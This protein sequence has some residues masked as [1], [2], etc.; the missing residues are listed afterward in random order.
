MIRETGRGQEA[1]PPQPNRWCFIG[2]A[3]GCWAGASQVFG[4]GADQDSDGKSSAGLCLRRC[5][6]LGRGRRCVAGQEPPFLDAGAAPLR[7]LDNCWC[8]VGQ[9][10]SA[11]GQGP[12]KTLGQGPPKIVTIIVPLVYACGAVLHRAGATVEALGRGVPR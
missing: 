12:P 8:C 10:R 3:A 5:V 6:A 11:A 9:G 7:F 4:A 2:R 1:M